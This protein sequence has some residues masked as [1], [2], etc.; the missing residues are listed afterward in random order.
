LLGRYV[1]T[2][3]CRGSTDVSFGSTQSKHFP[4]VG[5]WAE[6]GKNKNNTKKSLFN[7]DI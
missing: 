1:V 3:Q 6:F 5:I 7:L 4:N 2:F